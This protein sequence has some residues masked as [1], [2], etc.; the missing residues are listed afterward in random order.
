MRLHGQAEFFQTKKKNLI[1]PSKLVKFQN[2]EQG[3]L[4]QQMN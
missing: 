1:W 4:V 2:E 3:G